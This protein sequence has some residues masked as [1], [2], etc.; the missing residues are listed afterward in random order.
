VVLLVFWSLL[1]A[2]VLYEVLWAL[3][4]LTRAL[5][6]VVALVEACWG[7]YFGALFEYLGGR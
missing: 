6:Q 7:V 2:L 4:L 3:G 5:G 1:F